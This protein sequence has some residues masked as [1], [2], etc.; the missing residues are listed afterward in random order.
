M[1]SSNV[2]ESG[3]TGPDVLLSG[4]SAPVCSARSPAAAA[5]VPPG[6]WST[7][8]SLATG[9][10]SAGSPVGLSRGADRSTAATPSS[11]GATQGSVPCFAG[12]GRCGVSVAPGSRSEPERPAGH[13]RAS[14]SAADGL[15]SGARAVEA[16]STGASRDSPACDRVGA[17]ASAGGASASTSAAG[18]LGAASPSS[19]TR[20]SSDTLAGN[21]ATH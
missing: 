8:V 21:S 4:V 13:V 20:A 7:C 3:S 9:S 19:E 18:A 12:L 16:P 10:S 17:T 2:H 14:R 15:S 5:D 1:L 6:Q 11:T